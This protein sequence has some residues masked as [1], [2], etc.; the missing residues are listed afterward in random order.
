MQ[1]SNHIQKLNKN[2]KAVNRLRQG[3]PKFQ[4]VLRQVSFQFTK[5]TINNNYLFIHDTH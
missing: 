4:D 2:K 1:N 5:M 3:A